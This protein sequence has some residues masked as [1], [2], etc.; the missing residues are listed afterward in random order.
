M[1]IESIT[2]HDS[3]A[4]H[5]RL[6]K[7]FHEWNWESDSAS[8][9]LYFAKGFRLRSERFARSGICDDA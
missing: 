1:K 8:T 7:A 4:T 2:R 6:F 9:V 3:T 5:V